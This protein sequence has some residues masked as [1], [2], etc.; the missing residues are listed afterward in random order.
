VRTHQPAP[1]GLIAL[2]RAIFTLAFS[3]DGRLLASGGADDVIRLWDL[4]GSSYVQVRTLF[5]H[6]DFIRSVAFSPDGQTLASGS[7]DTTA[8]L[9]DVA[10]GTEVGGPLTGDTESIERVAF[11]R[12]GNYLATGSADNTVRLWQAV[13]LPPSF[14]D[15]RN[16][17]CDF[18]GAGLSR[19]EW[20]QYAPNIAFQQTCRRRTPS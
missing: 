12:D 7:S 13:K 10:T 9:W 18:L 17:V 1:P 14:A 19:A 11:S 5:G 20:S 4:H 6:S 3:P 15:V 8:R 16:E 2:G